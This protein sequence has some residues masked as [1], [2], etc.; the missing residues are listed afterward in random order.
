MPLVQAWLDA[1]HP[2]APR[3]PT[4]WRTVTIV[5]TVAGALGAGTAYYTRRRK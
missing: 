2:E 5:A 4:P 3:R 1:G